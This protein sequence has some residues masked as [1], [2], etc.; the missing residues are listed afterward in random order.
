VT[1]EIPEQEVNGVDTIVGLSLEPPKTIELP[2]NVVYAAEVLRANWNASF[3]AFIPYCFKC[4]EPL[5]WHQH[6]KQV[7]FHCPS[8]KREWVKSKSWEE[9]KKKKCR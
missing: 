6:P 1:Q 8:C 9:D 7:L 2:Y 5:V 3:I 4:K